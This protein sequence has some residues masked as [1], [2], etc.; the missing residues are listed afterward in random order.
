MRIFRER[1]GIIFITA[2]VVVSLFAVDASK[3]DTADRLWLVLILG[4]SMVLFPIFF[5]FDGVRKRPLVSGI[6]GL[7]ITCVWASFLFSQ[8]KNYGFSEAV[9]YTFS[10]LLGLAVS[11]IAPQNRKFL[12]RV[13][14][15]IGLVSSLYSFWYFQTHGEMRMAGLFLD[16]FDPRHFFP[17]AFANFLLMAWPLALVLYPR[18]K[19]LT[20]I[21]LIILLSALYGTF[22]RGAWSALIIQIIVL[23]IFVI[24][25]KKYRDV[26]R[27][28]KKYVAITILGIL[29]LT[30]ALTFVR[31][32]NFHMIG[33]KD[34][35]L[36]SNSESSTSLTE[37]KDFWVGSLKLIKDAPLFGYGPMS[38]R[39]VYPRIQKNFLATSDHPHNWILKMGVEEGIPT[40]ALFIFF[41]CGVGYVVIKNR[42]NGEVVLLGTALFG[43][44]V[45]NLVDYNLNFIPIIAAF[46]ILSGSIISLGGEKNQSQKFSAIPIAFWIIVIAA[47]AMLSLSE[48]VTAAASAWQKSQM[49]RDRFAREAEKLLQQGN[50]AGAR[51]LLSIHLVKNPYDAYALHING[52]PERAL[53]LDPMNHFS[54]Y[55]AYLEKN[56]KLPADLKAQLE[57]LLHEYDGLLQNNIHYTAFSDNPEEAAKIYDL[58]GK[59]DR[60]QSIRTQAEKIR[61]GFAQANDFNKSFGPRSPLDFFR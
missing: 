45:H 61:M 2:I 29:I 17:N 33:V 37:R 3:Y 53:A 14:L 49:P 52:N 30:G 43:G 56:K 42:A 10:A 34:K 47:T 38:F 25:Q 21:F 19:S 18:K 8:T 20:T 22:S 48:M 9:I 13:L 41:L 54:Y 15:V 39:Y 11:T 7:W 5:G 32:K 12:F 44:L 16:A 28:I 59:H 24:A 55:R 35:V 23:A 27:G 50:A 26:M 31:S 57:R 40:V 60:A 46:F 51:E 36:F 58:L 1:I 6:L 4:A